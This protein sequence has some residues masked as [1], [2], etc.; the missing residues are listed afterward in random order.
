MFRSASSVYPPAHYITVTTTPWP[1]A[2]QIEVVRVGRWVLPYVTI[3]GP[4]LGVYLWCSFKGASD[5]FEY[6]GA[7]NSDLRYQVHVAVA[8]GAEVYR[9]A[10]TVTTPTASDLKGNPVPEV[11]DKSEVVFPTDPVGFTDEKIQRSPYTMRD[12]IDIEFEWRGEVDPRIVGMWSL[13]TMWISTSIELGG[14]DENYVGVARA[15]TGGVPSD[16][17]DYERPTT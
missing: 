9:L 2:V 14:P 1:R 17:I 15:T 7:L 8:A 11:D 3:K 10:I 6:Y 13:T 5:E 4:V 12:P 16:T